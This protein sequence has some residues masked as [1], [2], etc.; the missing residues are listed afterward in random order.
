MRLNV[1]IWYIYLKGILYIGVVTLSCQ[2]KIFQNKL[3]V[4][5]N[6]LLGV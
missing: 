5:N 1:N 4:V 2:F 6:M 3:G